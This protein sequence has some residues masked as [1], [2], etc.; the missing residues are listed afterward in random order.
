M[1]VDDLYHK[2]KVAVQKLVLYV[3]VDYQNVYVN[4]HNVYTKCEALPQTGNKWH[5][6]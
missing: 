1:M 2:L 4:Y 6:G 3:N 5:F